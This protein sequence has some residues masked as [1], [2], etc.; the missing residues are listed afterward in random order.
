MRLDTRSFAVAAGTAAAIAFASCALAV[1]IAPAQT[2]AF[3]GYITH[4]DLSSVSRPLGWDGFIVGVVAWWGIAA[5]VFGL[6]AWVYNRLLG[7]RSELPSV[8]QAVERH[9]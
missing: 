1:A 8:R 3:L 2:T 6:A 7:V 9:G 5:G 4:T